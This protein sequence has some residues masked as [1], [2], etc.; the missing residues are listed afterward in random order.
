VVIFGD[1]R[2]T[3]IFDEILKACPPELQP[4]LKN[5]WRGSVSEDPS[6]LRLALQDMLA[7][8]LN[9]DAPTS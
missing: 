3:A 8:P 5:L 7:G 1:Y 2:A 9:Q 4:D 6:N